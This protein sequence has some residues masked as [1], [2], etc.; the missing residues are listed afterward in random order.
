MAQAFEDEIV[1]AGIA[2][3]AAGYRARALDPIAVLDRY[4]ARIDRYDGALNGYVARDADDARGAAEESR[5]RWAAGNPRSPIDGV[6]I[7]VKANI[8]VAGLP[9]HAGIDAYR[10]RIATQDAPCIA[11]LRAAGAVILGLAN[12]HEAAA[13]ATTDNRSFGRTHNPWRHG[14]SPAGSSGGSGAVVAAGLAAG[15]LGTDT[16]GSVRLPAAFTG[17]YGLKPGYGAISIQGVVPLTTVLDHVGVHARSAGD[18]A[19][20]FAAAA[21]HGASPA[22]TAHAADRPLRLA[23]LDLASYGPLDDDIVAALA[24]TADRARARGHAIETVPLLG[25]EVLGQLSELIN[26]ELFAVHAERRG[27]APERFSPFL[28]RM[29]AEGGAVSAPAL[30]H[31]H[32]ARIAAADAIRDALAGYDAMLMPTAGLRPHSFEAKPDMRV[33][34]FTTLGNLSGLPAMAFPAGLDRDGLPAS[35]QALAWDEATALHLAATLADEVGAPP[36]FG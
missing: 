9:W 2:G 8:A 24:R 29:M 36:G 31:A 10:D 21:R 17:S 20:L 1:A 34:M 12:M 30:A 19:L 7:A 14:Y 5:A 23:Q 22:A 28:Q 4:H 11:R 35:V 18:C 26:A 27:E 32:I 15:A 16:A 3:L 6:P 13:G 33:A 25:I